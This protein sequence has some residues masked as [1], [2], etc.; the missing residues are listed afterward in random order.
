M[1]SPP[2]GV[3]APIYPTAPTLPEYELPDILLTIPSGV[4]LYYID[5]EGKA[6]TTLPSPTF[7]QV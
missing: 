7:L 2:P 3:P 6:V 4:V 1:E 5:Q